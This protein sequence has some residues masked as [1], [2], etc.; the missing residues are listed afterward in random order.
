MIQTQ[1]KFVLAWFKR[2]K[3]GIT[4][5]W[6][7]KVFIVDCTIQSWSMWCQ[8]DSNIIQGGINVTQISKRDSK[9]DSR[10]SE[11]LEEN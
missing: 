2:D 7:S 9:V 1:F 10:D 5:N 3:G 6:N 4:R 8:A 11:R